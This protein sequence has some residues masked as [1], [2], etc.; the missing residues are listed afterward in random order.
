M[1]NDL[2]DFSI[3][4]EVLVEFEIE[5]EP[6]NLP[7]F[8]TNVQPDELWLAL[9]TPD[10]R[11]AAL[12]PGQCVHLTFSRGGGALVVE[13]E[14]LRRFVEPAKLGMEKSRLFAVSRPQG[15]DQVQRRAHVRVDIDLSVHVRSFGNIGSGRVVSERTINVGAGG[16]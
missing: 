3:H 10:Q 16:L 2:K 5:G 13:S 15:V 1:A 11:L 7:T 8:V 6:Q 9:R 14:F 4:D 12:A